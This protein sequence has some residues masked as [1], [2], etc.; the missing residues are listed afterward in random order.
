MKKAE[1]KRQNRAKDEAYKE[2][3]WESGKLIE[4]NHNQRYYSPEYTRALAKRL[5]YYITQDRESSN[6]SNEFLSRFQSRKK[7]IIDLIILW[8]PEVSREELPEHNYLKSLLE[9]YWDR[10][11]ENK[12]D[13]ECL[14][15]IIPPEEY[16]Q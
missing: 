2:E 12:E 11:I 6:T 16:D 5:V 4:E 14:L 13:P 15:E 1:R 10:I 9:T 7:K 3:A 8:N